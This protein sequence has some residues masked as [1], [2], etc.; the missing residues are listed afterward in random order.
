MA[1]RPFHYTCPTEIRFGSGVFA[2]VPEMDAVAGRRCMFL[3]YPGFDDASFRE[4]LGASCETLCMPD[5]FEENP[6]EEFVRR[7]AEKVVVEKIDT[8]I[9]VGGGSSIDTAKAAAWFAGN[10]NWDLT[11]DNPLVTANKLRIIAVPTTA[12]TG[13]EVTPYAILT[14]ADNHKRILNHP[15]LIPHLAVCDP[16]LT[17]TLP[18]HVTAHS[19]IDALSHAIEAYMSQPCEGI[20]EDM[21][22]ASLKRGI[23]ALPTAVS[24][25]DNISARSEMMLSALEGGLVLAHCGTVMVHALG[26]CLTGAFRYSHGLSNAIILPAFIDVLT[27]LGS[28]RAQHILTLSTV[29][30]PVLFNSAA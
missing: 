27:D 2:T 21:A 25:P 19:G 5:G 9:A 16:L 12:G 1:A 24:D 13:S 8:I 3:S 10:P 26:Y 6:T 7:L 29:T 18:R 15:S 30:F 22:L 11:G 23:K 20:L 4:R 28:E 14:D 17:I